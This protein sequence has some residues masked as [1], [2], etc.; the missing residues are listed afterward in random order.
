MAFSAWKLYHSPETER[1]SIFVLVDRKNLEEQ[2]EKDFGFI[3]V[4]IEKI[5]T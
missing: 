2:I 5:G 1:P 3:E 4:P